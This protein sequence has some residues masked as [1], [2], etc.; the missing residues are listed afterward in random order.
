MTP[1]DVQPGGEELE[2]YKLRPHKTELES[3]L[4][5]CGVDE[6]LNLSRGKIVGALEKGEIRTSCST[7]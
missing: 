1:E 6:V 3:L 4:I 5:S 7:V 2:R